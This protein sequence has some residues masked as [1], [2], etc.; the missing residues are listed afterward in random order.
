MVREN[1]NVLSFGEFDEFGV[2]LVVVVGTWERERNESELTSDFW[3]EWEWDQ[4]QSLCP[5]VHMQS[6]WGAGLLSEWK[7]DSW[8]RGGERHVRE[9]FRGGKITLSV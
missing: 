5:K 6:R 4:L 8:A 7:S 3:S 1:D 9:S 2:L